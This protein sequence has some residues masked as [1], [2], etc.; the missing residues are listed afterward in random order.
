M[1][2]NPVSSE[3]HGIYPRDARHKIPCGSCDPGL[4][5]LSH[6]P[7][8]T[9]SEADPWTRE[10]GVTESQTPARPWVLCSEIP[11]EGPRNWRHRMGSAPAACPGPPDQGLLAL[12]LL[13]QGCLPR[14]PRPWPPHPG[15]PCPGLLDPGLHARGSQL[16]WL[17]M[18]EASRCI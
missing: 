5:A 4:Q 7:C 9:L 16:P 8:L 18:A 2:T 13:A 12:G 1:T 11:G 6:L 15:L 14:A 3:T 17:I 10:N